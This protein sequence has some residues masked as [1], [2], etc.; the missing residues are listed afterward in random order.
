MDVFEN[1]KNDKTVRSKSCHLSS[2]R[3]VAGIKHFFSNSPIEL[4]WFVPIW[5]IQKVR[6]GGAM[7]ETGPG[8]SCVFRGGAWTQSLWLQSLFF[9]KS[10]SY[11]M[12]QF[13]TISLLFQG[14]LMA[15]RRV[16]T[17]LETVG[18]ESGAWG[19]C[20]MLPSWWSDLWGLVAA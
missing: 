12:S 4:L 7:Y 20:W 6:F 16:S 1:K 8:L 19:P 10:Q 2:F 13:L 11:V 3:R 5:Q 9:P 15:F 14:R 17:S 18:P